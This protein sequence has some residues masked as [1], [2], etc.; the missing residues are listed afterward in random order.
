MK[1]FVNN[2]NNQTSGS[3]KFIYCGTNIE[4]LK[5]I[6]RENFTTSPY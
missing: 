4:K 3:G 2:E 5:L 6:L 1:N